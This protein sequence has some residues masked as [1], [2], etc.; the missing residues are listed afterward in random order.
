MPGASVKHRIGRH[1]ALVAAGL[2]LA[3]CS[4]TGHRFR[5]E[6]LAQFVPGQTTLVQA[7]RF[8][9][10]EPVNVYRQLDGAFTALWAHKAVAVTDAVYMRQELLLRFDA[11]GRFERVVD[12][13]NVMAR[14]GG[15]APPTPPA[16]FAASQPAPQPNP[17]GDASARGIDRPVV[18]YPLNP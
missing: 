13:V 8:L 15:A 3:G 9:E 18:T 11:G 12:S 2:L 1:I 4:T 16:P 14:P 10:A 17:L 7:E 6:G 5:S